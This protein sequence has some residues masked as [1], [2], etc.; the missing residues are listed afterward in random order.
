MEE[1]VNFWCRSHSRSPTFSHFSFN[2]R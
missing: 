1:K 2:H